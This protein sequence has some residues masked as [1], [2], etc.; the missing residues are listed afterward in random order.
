MAS[1]FNSIAQITA[2]K[3]TWKIRVRCERVWFKFMRSQPDVRTAM[4]ICVLDEEGDKIQAIIPKWRI[5]KLENIIKE[6]SFYVLENFEILPNNDEYAPTKHPY[7]LKFHECTSVRPSG[8]VNI[9]RYIFNFVNFSDLA[10]N[11]DYSLRVFDV[12]AEV[13]GMDELVKYDRDGRQMMRIKAHLRNLSGESIDC[14]LWNEFAIQ[15]AEYWNNKNWNV[16]KG[17]PVVIILQH[18]MVKRWGAYVNLQNSLF[19]SKLIINDDLEDINSYVK[20]LKENPIQL[21][22]SNLSRDDSSRRSASEI[23]EFPAELEFK[24]IADLDSI[25]E[26]CSCI[27]YCK[28]LHIQANQNW[29]YNAC[30]KCYRKV[31]EQNDKF[32]CYHCKVCPDAVI[33]RYRVHVRV[34]D[35]GCTATFVLFDSQVSTLIG[36]KAADLKRALE[37]AGE[38]ESFPDELEVLAKKSYLFKLD[39]NAYTLRQRQRVYTVSKL[40]DDSSVISKWCNICQ[41]DKSTVSSVGDNAKSSDLT[42]TSRKRLVIDFNDEVIIEGVAHSEQSFTAKNAKVKIEK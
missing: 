4:E 22:V 33:V 34:E 8:I 28:I 31:N 41:D 3:E 7:V 16:K 6:G 29:Y 12:I 5:S 25:N 36:K 15:M 14:T 30:N 13:Y 26:E 17:D 20:S 9:P 2:E 27:V 37:V 38:I 10:S 39:I 35:K 24:S 19:A 11:A 1:T 21:S 42:P 18:A 32:W 40:T 23:D